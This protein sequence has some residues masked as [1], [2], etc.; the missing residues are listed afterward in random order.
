MKKN[1]GN[2]ERVGVVEQWL[3][4]EPA[5]IKASTKKLSIGG[6]DSMVSV[7]EVKFVVRV[8]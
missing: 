1:F 2:G 7:A 6:L 5:W 8:A 4:Q 3:G